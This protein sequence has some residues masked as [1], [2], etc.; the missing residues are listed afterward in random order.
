MVKR[1]GRDGDTVFRIQR[2]DLDAGG[3]QSRDE[4]VRDIERA[5]GRRDAD[6]E[7]RDA[8]TKTSVAAVIASR[9]GPEIVRVPL[10]SQS[11]TWVSSNTLN[12]RRRVPRAR[13]R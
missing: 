12:R 4:L 8:L 13:H 10:S 6:L 5:D 1:K 3:D 2:Q 11:T 9:A 7:E